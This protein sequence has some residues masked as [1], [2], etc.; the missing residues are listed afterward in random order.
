MHSI[1]IVHLLKLLFNITANGII[2]NCLYVTCILIIDRE[3]I[4]SQ[5]LSIASDF[6]NF[7]DF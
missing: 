4:E 1:F 3:G 2:N 6:Y 5:F 7:E